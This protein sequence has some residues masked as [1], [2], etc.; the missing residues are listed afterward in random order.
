MVSLTICVLE[1]RAC[2]TSRT[3][4]WAVGEEPL[5]TS[6]GGG[7]GGGR[8]EGRGG[9]GGRWKEETGRGG[10]G[11]RGKEETGRGGGGGR[12]KEETGRGGRVLTRRQL[13]EHQ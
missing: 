1:V 6:R 11:G 12:G 8:G 7:G 10:G 4:S 5:N 9:G 2:S 3:S 13:V